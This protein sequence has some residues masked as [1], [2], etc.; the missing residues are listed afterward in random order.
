MRLIQLDPLSIVNSY[1][2]FFVSNIE[3]DA[4]VVKVL[5]GYAKI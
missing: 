2:F 4:E 1:H 5:E 3:L